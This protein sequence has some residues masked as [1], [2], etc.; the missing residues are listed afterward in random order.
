MAEPACVERRSPAPYG[1]VSP[2]AERA[3]KLAERM[4][5]ALTEA[6]FV[7]ERDFPSLHGDITVSD[8]PFVTLGRLTP[9]VVELLSA[10]LVGCSTV[11]QA[12][13][14]QASAVIE[15]CGDTRRLPA[16]VIS[17]LSAV[18][19]RRARRLPGEVPMRRGGRQDGPIRLS[20][21]GSSSLTCCAGVVADSLARESGSCRHP[22]DHP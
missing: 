14:I 22:R 18:G 12:S 4:R 7:V 9:A 20:D 1:T 8:E 2:A 11:A 3:R 17:L 6:G 10:A 15:P 16:A 5:T 13:Y 19:A 21:G